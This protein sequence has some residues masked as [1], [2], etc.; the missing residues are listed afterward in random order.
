MRMILEWKG[1]T[2]SV[3]S[4]ATCPARTKDEHG[5]PW[6]EIREVRLREQIKGLFPIMNKN[7]KYKLCPIY[8]EDK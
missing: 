2:Y 5:L 6:C 1:K 7:L 4:C 8:R 3:E